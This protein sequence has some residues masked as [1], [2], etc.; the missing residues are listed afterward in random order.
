MI[1]PSE[2][3]HQGKTFINTN[4]RPNKISPNQANGTQSQPSTKP[5]STNG[6]SPPSSPIGKQNLAATGHGRRSGREEEEDPTNTQQQ[7]TKP[8]GVPIPL[9]PNHSL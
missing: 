1:N 8:I 9:P 4:T 5:T 2:I 3:N 6:Q 7:A